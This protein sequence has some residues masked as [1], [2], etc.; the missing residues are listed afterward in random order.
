MQM[1]TMNTVK[2]VTAMNVVNSHIK[3]KKIVLGISGG[4]DSTTAALLLLEKGFDVYGMYFN[5]HEQGDGERDRA[6]QALC[7]AY[8][9]CGKSAKDAGEKFLY[10]DASEEFRK[11]VIADFC[12]EYGAGRTPNPCTL[13]NPKIKFHLLAEAADEIGADFLATGHYA[14]VSYDEIKN[15]YYITESASKKDQSYMLYRLPQKVL[16]RLI[17]PLEEYASKEDVRSIAAKNKLSNAAQSDSQEICF[18]DD[19]MD[20]ADFIKRQGGKTGITEG[21]FIDQNGKVLGYHKGL[22]NYT[23]GQRKG[24]GIAL[25]YPVFVTSLDSAHNTVTLGKSEELFQTEVWICDLF[26]T[27]TSGEQLPDL[28]EEKKLA[29]KIRYAAPKSEVRI[30]QKQKGTLRLRFETPQRAMAP[31][32]SLVL[33]EGS[34]VIGGGRIDFVCKGENHKNK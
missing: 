3:N 33:Y 26:F 16:R 28:I 20:K 25:G 31:G 9:A 7:E 21:N 19:G 8:C 24:L 4:V 29:A 32:Q 18:I 13:C 2:A 23:V 17:L 27:E 11:I 22:V 10:R 34:R 1:K 6:Q 15:I 5:I 12:R 14:S 30:I